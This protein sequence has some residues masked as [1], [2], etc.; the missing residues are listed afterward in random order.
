MSLQSFLFVSTIL[1]TP[2][3]NSCSTGAMLWAMI[4]IAKTLM[5]MRDGCCAEMPNFLPNPDCN[6]FCQP[7]IIRHQRKFTLWHSDDNAEICVKF[8]IQKSENAVW[9]FPKERFPEPHIN[10]IYE[11]YGWW[12]LKKLL[13]LRKHWVKIGLGRRLSTPPMLKCKSRG[14]GRELPRLAL[15]HSLNTSA[16]AHPPPTRP[17][18]LPRCPV[19][20]HFLFHF[21]H[22][23]IQCQP[24]GIIADNHTPSMPDSSYCTPSWTIPPHA[25]ILDL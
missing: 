14:I 11:C 8:G 10:A 5:V 13:E 24:D 22:S 12:N 19:G 1:T 21:R 3:N 15:V 25:V 17:G 9:S 6:S 23:P 7:V 16:P 2:N 4:L 18:H 20:Q